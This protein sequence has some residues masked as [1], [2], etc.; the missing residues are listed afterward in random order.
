MNREGGG[1]QCPCSEEWGEVVE[2]S[3]CCAV[4]CRG[5]MSLFVG[6][7]DDVALAMEQRPWF[8]D[9][10]GGDRA[11]L[12]SSYGT[13]LFE[14]D[15]R[16]WALLGNGTVSILCRLESLR[17]DTTEQGPCSMDSDGL[18]SR[19]VCRG[20]LSLFGGFGWFS[21]EIGVQ[22]DSVLV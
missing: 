1:E 19:S 18:G 20:M 21:L 6:R 9:S 22:W 13:V 4:V 14:A 16:G 10:S 7:M 8:V 5:T 15:K 17:M 11:L 3:D 12:S 2:N